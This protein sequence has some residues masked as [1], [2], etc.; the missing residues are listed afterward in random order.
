MF[1][2]IDKGAEL[3]END[4]EFAY[5]LLMDKHVL[6]VPGSGFKWAQPDHFRIVILPEAEILRKAVLDIGDFIQKNL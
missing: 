1:P 5:N 3:I 4:K 2:K 6:I